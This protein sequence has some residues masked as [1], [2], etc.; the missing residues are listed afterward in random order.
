MGGNLEFMSPATLR[1]TPAAVTLGPQIGILSSNNS[2]SRFE[3]S[4]YVAEGMV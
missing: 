4:N 1:A 3:T 2:L